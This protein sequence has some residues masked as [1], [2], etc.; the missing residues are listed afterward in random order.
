[1]VPFSFND[2]WRSPRGAEE[3]WLRIVLISDIRQIENYSSVAELLKYLKATDKT[4][5]TIS[6]LSGNFLSPCMLTSLDGGKAMGEVLNTV[7]IDYACFG[8]HEFNV[9]FD[10]LKLR[11]RDFNGK[12]LNSNIV[13]PKF[14]GKD[15]AELPKCDVL[16]V[17]RKRVCISGSITENL[18]GCRPGAQPEI[19]NPT[20]AIADIWKHAGAKHGEL[21]LFLP[22][23]Y[24]SKDEDRSMIAKLHELDSRAKSMMPIICGGCEDETCMEEMQGSLIVKVG[25]R[26]R[27]AAVIDVWWD[28]DDNLQRSCKLFPLSEFELLPPL[29]SS[30]SDCCQEYVL[31][32]VGL[33]A[34][35]LAAPILRV[36]SALD[37]FR[38]CLAPSAL[39]SAL[40]QRVKLALDGVEIVLLPGGAIQ[41][42]SLHD[43]P[44][45]YSDLMK[46]LPFDTEMAIIYVPGKIIAESIMNS[47]STPAV[48]RPSYLHTDEDCFFDDVQTLSHIDNQKLDPEKLYEVAIYQLLLKGTADVI[49]PLLS[50]VQQNVA[51]PDLRYCL[52]AKHLITET[53]VK[54]MWRKMVAYKGG[55]QKAFLQID[56]CEDVHISKAAL[57]AQIKEIDVEDEDDP[58]KVPVGLLKILIDSLN[59]DRNGKV[60]LAEIRKIMLSPV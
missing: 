37:T 19:F 54:L 43:G 38:T 5:R 23:T 51:L 50:Y 45:T 9:G 28:E 22:L 29:S 56:Q 42:R 40:L 8:R 6:V 48:V 32:Q 26:A 2:D 11:I 36:P 35:V 57:F 49:Q 17:G 53:C 21:D 20:F 24:Q 31:K 12:W 55:L 4:C 15:G 3:S 13:A 58:D 1:V 7:P 46:E 52:S 44:F 60:S 25:E 47:R 16:Q 18:E 59:D 39:A 34:K 10:A 14:C 33:L 30:T 41:G 27:N